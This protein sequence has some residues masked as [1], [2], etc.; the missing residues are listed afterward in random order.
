MMLSVDSPQW[1]GLLT[2][3]CRR[4]NHLCNLLL[5]SPSNALQSAPWIQLDALCEVLDGLA[6]QLGLE[7]SIALDLDL[8]S[9][10]LQSMRTGLAANF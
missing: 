5:C 8:S 4:C 9:L 7:G 2:G 6:I 3:P 1:D 10:A